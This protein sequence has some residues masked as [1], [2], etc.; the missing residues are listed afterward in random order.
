MSDDTRIEAELQSSM[1]ALGETSSTFGRSW[2]AFK[3]DL[4]GDPHVPELEGAY[5]APM[6]RSQTELVEALDALRRAARRFEETSEAA[7]K[8]ARAHDGRR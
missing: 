6:L 7:E 4:A 1:R 5:V 3:S 2:G 8:D